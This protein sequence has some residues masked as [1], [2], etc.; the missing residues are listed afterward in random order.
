MEHRLSRARTRCTAGRVTNA[1]TEIR[2]W[3]S[4]A[5]WIRNSNLGERDCRETREQILDR[6]DSMKLWPWL[7]YEIPMQLSDNTDNEQRQA[8]KDEALEREVWRAY[9]DKYDGMPPWQDKRY[10][11]A[12]YENFRHNY[13]RAKPARAVGERANDQ[14]LT[15]AAIL[16][17]VRSS[18]E[19]NL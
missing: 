11:R 14:R 16:G 8:R 17:A 13:I 7:Q 5:E 1:K 12:C 19:P 15:S 6:L 18:R 4:C 10:A 9:L 2:G 3:G